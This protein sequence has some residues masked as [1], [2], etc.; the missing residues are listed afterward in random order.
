MYFHLLFSASFRRPRG[1][2]N[3][4]QYPSHEKV[5]CSSCLFGL[6]TVVEEEEAAAVVVVVVVE[7]ENGV[8]IFSLF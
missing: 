6:K 4:S 3:P 5:S 7:T 1:A 2:H 8:M